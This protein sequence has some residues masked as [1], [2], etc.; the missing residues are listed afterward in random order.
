LQLTGVVEAGTHSNRP[1][2]LKSFQPQKSTKS[3]KRISVDFVPFVLLCGRSSCN[4]SDLV[5]F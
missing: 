5:Y 4:E 1:L 3:T 2:S